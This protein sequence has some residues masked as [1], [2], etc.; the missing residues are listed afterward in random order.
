MERQ[1][2]MKLLEWVGKSHKH[3]N[4]SV[5][6]HHMQILDKHTADSNGDNDYK[7][8]LVLIGSQC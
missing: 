4:T 7:F 6:F 3:C 5:I 8:C 2:M 1:T